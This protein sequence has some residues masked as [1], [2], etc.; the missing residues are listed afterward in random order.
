MTQ[1]TEKKEYQT[2]E[3]EYQT[4]E[5]KPRAASFPKTKKGVNQDVKKITVK[6][7]EASR[8]VYHV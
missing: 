1:Q 8:Q 6:S 5:T 7:A 2:G 4:G 3:K